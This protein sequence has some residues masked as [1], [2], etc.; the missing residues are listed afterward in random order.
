MTNLEPVKKK[1]CQ[2]L[3]TREQNKH[4]ETREKKKKS[5]CYVLPA[6][7]KRTR[8]S[9]FLE[10]RSKNKKKRNR[11]FFFLKGNVCVFTHLE[12]VKEEEQNKDDS[13][14][15]SL[16]RGCHRD[17][18]SWQRPWSF[19]HAA[20]KETTHTH[21]EKSASHSLKVRVVIIIIIPGDI[22]NIQYFVR[23]CYFFDFKSEPSQRGSLHDVIVPNGWGGTHTPKEREEGFGI[24]HNVTPLSLSCAPP[25]PDKE[26]GITRTQVN[27]TFVKISR[28]FHPL[29]TCRHAALHGQWPDW[30][31]ADFIFF[32]SFVPFKDYCQPDASRRKP[33]SFRWNKRHTMG[34]LHPLIYIIFF[35]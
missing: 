18:S 17:R 19:T 13:G 12:R 7:R 10:L 8:P 9:H 27:S 6:H 21:T 32:S 23:A 11:F 30:F 28:R 24:D 16:N 3:H 5:S 14:H 29:V 31:T 22:Q 2:I 20:V 15:R 26:K 35:F 33:V 1:H 4:S 25:P 34:L